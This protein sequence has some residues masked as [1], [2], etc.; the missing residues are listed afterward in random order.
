M[1]KKII[2][3]TIIILLLNNIYGQKKYNY[4]IATADTIVDNYFGTKIIDP[5]RWM[6]NPNDPRLVVWL[7]EQEKFC[8]MVAKKQTRV[9]EL[10]SQIASMYNDVYRKKTSNYKIRDEKFTSK[11]DFKVD[12]N[13]NSKSGN[14]MY[15]NTDQTNYRL[16]IK[17]SDIVNLKNSKIEYTSKIVNNQNGLA[18]V[19]ISVNGSDWNTGYLFDLTTGKQ[20]PIVLNNLKGPDICWHN[21]T[22][23]FDA[24]NAPVKGRERFDKAGGQ[25]LYKLVVGTD[26]L[27]QLI[28]TNTDTTGTNNFSFNIFNDKLF[29][30][31]FINLKGTYYKTISCASLNSVNFFPKNFLVYP[32]LESVN[33]SV[34]HTSNDSVWL[35]TNWNAPNRMLLLANVNVPNKVSEFVPEYDMVLEKVNKLGKNKLA[36]VYLQNGQ[37]IVLVY[38]FKGKLLKKFDFPKG[39]KVNYF[40][41]GYDVE[42]THF[43]VSSFYHPE[44]LYQL[45]L[46]D[47]TFKPAEA[48]TVPYDVTNIETRYVLYKSA[49]GTQ[50]P[51]YVTCKKDIIL[52]GK[53]PVMLYV[54][55]GYGRVVEPF[56]DESITLFIAHGGVLAVPNVR[57]SDVH[58]TNWAID[59]R[60]LKKQNAIDD[61]IAAAEYLIN[62]NYT[63]PEKI[64]A[65][66]ASHGGL[67]VAAAMVQRP[68]LFKAVIAE[69][70]VYD[71]LRFSNYTVGGVNTNIVEFGVPDNKTDFDNLFSYSPLHNIKNNV[72]YPNLLLIT[73]DSDDRVPPMHSY[74]FIAT[75]QNNADKSGLYTLFVTKGAGHRGSLTQTDFEEMLLFKYYFIF[76]NLDIKLN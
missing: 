4:P 6:E 16:L 45:S 64:V 8:T 7:S 11:Y 71:M 50:V 60:R 28:Y 33:L 24:Y 30:Y 39:K 68:A 32:N 47:L 46:T 23:Y 42:H 38:D 2:S 20:L 12:I 69:A 31:H 15:K 67:M 26:T 43:T 14:L 40:Y 54:Y 19:T 37:N 17:A 65:S 74:K 22:L 21:N 35:L 62:E 25:K 1:T 44:L 58:G 10:R 57:G 63:Q 61:L 27:P 41:D 72:K 13:N 53:N 52:N 56:F 59:G 66:G 9:W 5:Y 49:D 29:I 51:M 48:L 75:I 70:G 36:L 34:V 18:V 3:F 76:D 73:G 55:G